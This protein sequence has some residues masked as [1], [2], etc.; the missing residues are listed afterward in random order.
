MVTIVKRGEVTRLI[1][2]TQWQAPWRGPAPH[3][4]NRMVTLRVRD[5]RRWLYRYRQEAEDRA[6]ED[7]KRAPLRTFLRSVFFAVNYAS[8]VGKRLP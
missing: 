7:A 1:Q 4:G 2:E 6:A 3:T 5:Q 8:E